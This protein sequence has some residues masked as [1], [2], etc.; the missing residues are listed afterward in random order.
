MEGN[1]LNMIIENELTLEYHIQ[2]C[3][4][5]PF[6]HKYFNHFMDTVDATKCS[7]RIQLKH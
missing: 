2:A 4:V 1:H 3:V 7:K 6:V 5:F